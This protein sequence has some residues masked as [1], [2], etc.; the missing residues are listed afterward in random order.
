MDPTGFLLEPILDARAPEEAAQQALASVPFEDPSGARRSLQSL[1]RLAEGHPL[2]L[3]LIA[4]ILRLLGRHAAPDMALNHFERWAARTSNPVTVYSL[5]LQDSRFL[6]G[7][8]RLFATS[9][10]LAEILIRDPRYYDLLL[11]PPPADPERF[12]DFLRRDLDRLLRVLPTPEARRDALRR[13]KRRA[14]LAIAWLDIMGF[15]PMPVTS[16]KISVLADVLVQKA[17]A[18]CREE[19]A[20]RYPGAAQEVAFAIISMGKL[21]GAELNYSS[22]ID[23]IFVWDSPDTARPEHITYAGKLAARIVSAL[24]Q[25]TGEGFV[26]RVDMRLRPEGRFG[27]LVRTLGAYREY[28]AQ[29][30]EFWERQALLKAR[31]IA[32]DAGL[33]RRFMELAEEV[34]YPG[35]L[36]A[37]LISDIRANK[38]AVELKVAAAG[39]TY[40]NVKEG[41]GTIRDI[42]FAVQLLQLLFGGKHPRLRTGNTLEA[43]DRLAEVG[44]LKP[45]ERDILSEH[46]QFFRTVEH[47]LQMRSDLPVR[48]LPSD[49]KELNR[50]AWRMGRESGDA[51]LEEF[52]SRAETVRA[53]FVELFYLTH[54]EEGPSPGHLGSLLY[55]LDTP[56][57]QKRFQEL[58]LRMGFQDPERSCQTLARLAGGALDNPTAWEVR[59]GFAAIADPLLEAAASSPYP[60]GALAGIEALGRFGLSRNAFYT[61]LAEQPAV[62]KILCQVTGTSAYLTDLL[63]RSPELLDVLF[64]VETLERPQAEEDLI[65]EW[66]FYI[67]HFRR[68]GDRLEA[69]RR[70]RRKARLRTAIRDIV[71]RVDVC[72]IHR[73]LS[74]LA[75]LCL[76]EAIRLLWSREHPG[77]DMPE[78]FAAIA[79]G[80]LGGREMEYGSDLDLIFLYDT[81]PGRILSQEEA[82]A[83]YSGLLGLTGELGSAFKALTPAGSLYELDL[84]LRPEGK[85]GSPVTHIDVCRSYYPSRALTWEKQS[86]TRARRVLGDPALSD[87]FFE[88]LRPIVYPDRPPEGMMEEIRAMKLRVERERVRPEEWETNVKLGFGGLADIEFL[89]QSHQLLYG[90]RHPALQGKNTFEAIET[91][92]QCG[93]LNRPETEDLKAAY[94]FL[95]RTRNMLFLL[96]GLA[97]DSLPSAPL[98]ALRLARALGFP[99]EA[100]L[101]ETYRH[102][103]HRVRAIYER[104]FLGK[105]KAGRESQV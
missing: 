86:L 101:H 7:L 13:A 15:D 6:E 57:I 44:L 76:R 47:R 30:V 82:Y 61:T 95:S 62:L 102:H 50:L 18:I 16:A 12:G 10:Y 71:C 46:Y 81:P 87:A 72:Q 60:D 84:R 45:W 79:C 41:R 34:A 29:W 28:W 22:D 91:M 25:P 83:R 53:M 31:P 56:A 42:E 8:L 17:F 9:E 75:D 35:L 5:L 69:L 24:Q 11:D 105:G 36:S 1:W 92:A 43:L 96:S 104:L 103:T 100:G 48:T 4:E 97:H 63:Q 78:A 64:D 85:K 27:S 65:E 67:S 58:L 99:S 51:F 74:D 32:G 33:G 90:A 20:E 26:F 54:E 59:R 94:R 89:V 40:T 93:L 88:I 49:P 80:R 70:F 38:E 77:E 21:G 14:T 3:D 2:A 98:E 68:F 23:L 73:E 52:R 37:D 39:E 66:S 19:L 55:G